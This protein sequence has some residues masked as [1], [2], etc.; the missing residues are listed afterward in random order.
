MA[1]SFTDLAAL[2]AAGFDDWIDVRSPAE[3]AEDHL[4]GAINLP[5]LSNAERAEVGTIYVQESRFR[6]KRIGAAKIARAVARHLDGP[7][8]DRPAGWRPLVYCWRGGQRSGAM[9]TI[10]T[11]IGW[12]AE[13]L[14]GG[15]RSWRRH[16][17]AALYDTPLAHRLV[18]LDGNTGTGKTALLPRL[19]ERGVQVIDLEGLAAHRGSLFGGVAEPQPAQKLFDSRVMAALSALDAGRVTVVE[20]ESNHIGRLLVP[21]SLWAAMKLAPRI[22]ISA[23]LP[24]R[25]AFLA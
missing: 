12:R 1:E 2:R 16:V 11:Q 21:P 15:Y 8:S 4:P 20:A 14:S 7:L 6:A 17:V 5:V 13:T 9:A 3:F 10:L 18:L 22:A 23:P 19:A 25:A 24:A